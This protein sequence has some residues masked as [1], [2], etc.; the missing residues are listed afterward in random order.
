MDPNLL[1]LIG[2]G[3][4]A[5]FFGY[6]FG[7]FEGRGQGRKQHAREISALQPEPAVAPEPAPAPTPVPTEKSL[8]RLSLDA[9]QAPRLELDDQPVDIASLTPDQRKRL[10]DLM[11]TMRPWIEGGPT[12]KAAVAPP[13]PPPAR[14]TPPAPPPSPI[15]PAGVTPASAAPARPAPEPGT[16]TTMVGQIDAIL[17]ARLMGTPLASRGIRIADA[18]EAGATIH[19]GTQSYSGVGDVPDKDVQSAIRAAIAEWEAKYTPS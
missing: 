18:G 16:P 1:T 4:A 7:L 19:V 17:Q 11:V 13:I 10:I 14:V 3:L 2:I 5:M 8:L 12:T 6:F 9:A 15:S